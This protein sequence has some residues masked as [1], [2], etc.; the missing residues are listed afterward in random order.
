MGTPEG[1]GNIA[2]VCILIGMAVGIAAGV[3]LCKNGRDLWKEG[4]KFFALLDIIGGFFLLSSIVMGLI[5]IL[6]GQT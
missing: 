2:V 3:F 6:F 4:R 1:I 5:A